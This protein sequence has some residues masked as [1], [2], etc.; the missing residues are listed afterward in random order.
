MS[1]NEIS[2][3]QDSSFNCCH[4]VISN[5]ALIV[6]VA[7]VVI[8]IL[9]AAQIPGLQAMGGVWY[10]FELAALP[11]FIFKI[12][13]CCKDNKLQNTQSMRQEGSGEVLIQEEPPKVTAVTY[14]NLPD[15]SEG[16]QLFIQGVQLDNKM[17][18]DDAFTYFEQAWEQGYALAGFEIA[19]GYSKYGN[20]TPEGFN[21]FKKKSLVIYKVLS[22]KNYLEAIFILTYEALRKNKWNEAVTLLEQAMQIDSD[23]QRVSKIREE[24]NSC[25]QQLNLLESLKIGTACMRWVRESITVEQIKRGN[26]LKRLILK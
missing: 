16:E 11:C 26:V 15:H 13:I 17:Q 10:A 18:H 12:I 25:N 24:L 6:G 1:V 23:K 22:D 14:D 20:R 5:V 9:V 2:A 19:S 4:S 3:T 7:L 8:G 21:E